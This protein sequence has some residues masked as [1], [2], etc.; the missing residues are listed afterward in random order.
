MCSHKYLNQETSLHLHIYIH[1]KLPVKNLYQVHIMLSQVLCVLYTLYI[2]MNQD[3]S[4]LHALLSF[5]TLLLQSL[6]ANLPPKP[7]PFLEWSLNDKGLLLLSLRDRTNYLTHKTISVSIF[8]AQIM[9]QKTFSEHNKKYY[10]KSIL[11]ITGTLSSRIA[12]TSD[13][14]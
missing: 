2:T 13:C 11:N 3:W 14:L 8:W 6:E 5:L 7:C 9:M 1:V 10:D 12:S 4:S